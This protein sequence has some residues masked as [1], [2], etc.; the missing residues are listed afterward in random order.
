MYVR[1]KFSQLRK[2]IKRESD[3]P[4]GKIYQLLFHSLSFLNP[5]QNKIGRTGGLKTEH[6][7]QVEEPVQVKT[8][9]ESVQ[10]KTEED[11]SDEEDEPETSKKS[12]GK[13]KAKETPSIEEIKKWDTEALIT[14]L[15][16]QELE[17]DNKYFDVFHTQEINGKTFL[18][19]TKK[20]LQNC[21]LKLGPAKTIAELIKELKKRASLSYHNLKEV[22][23]KHGIEGSNTGNI[24]QFTPEP[25]DIEDNDEEL[26]QCIKDIKR[27]MGIMGTLLVD[28]NEAD[29]CEYTIAIL[30]AAVYIARRITGKNITIS[31]LEII[32]K[33]NTGGVNYTIKETEELICITNGKQHKIATGFAQNLVQLESLYQSNKR[34]CK[35]DDGGSG[36]DYLYGIVS[37][38]T[39]WYFLLYSTGRI[40]CTSKRPYNIVFSEAA[41][42]KDSVEE[43][44]LRKNV[45]RVMEVIVGILIDRINIEKTPDSKK[46]RIEKYF[47]TE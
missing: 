33:E 6:V 23:N 41:L 24:S 4:S 36:F 19:L 38:A 28:S 9:E 42:E 29:R 8:A 45:K 46:A 47:K 37:T 12:K 21:G 18:E 20:E 15:Q 32:E 3:E 40:S 34:K 27:K 11:E 10:M 31:S 22:L 2:L 43:Q 13:L 30:H 7:V 26:E 35:A 5:R 39:D 17:L 1:E 16:K 25:Y 14:F 44:E